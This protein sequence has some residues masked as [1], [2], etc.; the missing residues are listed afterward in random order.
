M[1]EWAMGNDGKK[2]WYIYTM[3]DIL[4]GYIVKSQ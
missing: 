2:K 1:A 3:T 4:R